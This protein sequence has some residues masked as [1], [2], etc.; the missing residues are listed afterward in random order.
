MT[1]F[2]KRE[3]QQKFWDVSPGRAIPIRLRH[4]SAVKY[5]CFSPS[6]ELVATVCTNGTATIWRAGDG[7]LQA[8]PAVPDDEIRSIAFSPDSLL[9]ALGSAAGRVGLW[10]IGANRLLWAKP[11]H[12]S[13]I[14]RLLFSPSGRYLFSGVGY[15]LSPMLGKDWEVKVLEPQTGRLLG[16]MTNSQYGSVMSLAVSPDSRR[17]AIAH[18]SY[19]AEIW[20]LEEMR[21]LGEPLQANQGWV[22][23]ACFS[24]NGRWL[25]TSSGGN[26]T[27]LWDASVPANKPLQAYPHGS[28][29]Q[30]AAFSS[31]DRLLLTC[32]YDHTARVWDRE[33]GK[34]VTDPLPQAGQ[35]G[36]NGAFSPRTARC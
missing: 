8:Q 17:L 22:W 29:V 16:E 13:G 36:K 34:P 20:D 12:T 10:D 11:V 23:H 33:S 9:V 32:A 6:G 2:G 19:R 21:R 4:S 1:R 7:A 31:D 3:E 27:Q 24:H 28:G 14:T 30:F 15:Y 5:A 18:R 35:F 25:A 26:A